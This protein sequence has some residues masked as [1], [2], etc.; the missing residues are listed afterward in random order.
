IVPDDKLSLAIGKKGQNV[1]LASQLTGWRIDI[2]SESKIQ[3]L[4]RRAKEQLSS[5]DG[6]SRDIAETLFRLGW[7]SVGELAQAHPEELAAVPGIDRVDDAQAIIDGSRDFLRS[8]QRRAEDQRRESERRSR[9]SDREKLLEVP[10]MTPE[11]LD[12]LVASGV[13]SVETLAR[14]APDKLGEIAIDPGIVA[15][16]RHQAQ[17]WLG[18]IPANTPMPDAEAAAG[19]GSR[20]EAR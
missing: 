1:R 5:V 4:E 10:G 19:E 17:I 14:T 3:E 2:H 7:R 13:R 12:E 20:A 6:I 11:H 16:L 8:E 18:D 9:L 15:Q